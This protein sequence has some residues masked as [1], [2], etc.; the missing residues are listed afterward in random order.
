M[1]SKWSGLGLAVILPLVLG[2]ARAD[3]VDEITIRCQVDM[4]QFG[5]AMVQACVDEDLR[6]LRELNNY[7]EAHTPTLE[8]CLFQMREQ[9]YALVKDCVDRD[10]EALE[11]LSAYPEQYQTIISLCQRQHESFGHA[12]VKACVDRDIASGKASE[13]N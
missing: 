2:V 1:R 8:R 4:G 13:Q 3:I 7:H 6:A 11:A 5:D 12:A 10:I 9:G